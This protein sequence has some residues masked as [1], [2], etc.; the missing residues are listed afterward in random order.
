MTT[1]LLSLTV[2]TVLALGVGQH[3]HH[4]SHDRAN[5]GMG[6]DQ[7]KTTHHFLLEQ[8]GGTIEVTAR[9]ATDATSTNHIRMHLK[10]IAAAF[11]AGDFS[12]PVFVHDTTPPGVTVMKDRRAQM[13]FRYA[14][15][16]QGG[17]VVV[18]TDD[19]AALAALHDFLRFQIREHKTGDSLT[20]R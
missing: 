1:T 19:P 17:K 5:H 11:A 2:A 4:P 6:F 20:P 16:D 10:H 3:Q 14:D 13:T 9:D 7:D 15:V 18:R 12:R 8:S